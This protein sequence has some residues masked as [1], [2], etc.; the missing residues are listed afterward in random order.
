MT[1]L[2]F[3]L[4]AMLAGDLRRSDPCRPKGDERSSRWKIQGTSFCGYRL[5]IGG[6][7]WIRGHVDSQWCAMELP[8]ERDEFGT[9]GGDCHCWGDFLQPHG[10]CRT[11]RTGR[12]G[13]HRHRRCTHSQC[14]YR[15]NTISTGTGKFTVGVYLGH[16]SGSDGRLHDNRL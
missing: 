7:C 15:Y 14:R 13:I 1:W 11:R 3:T 4:I 5:F 2:V 12:C 10:I 6:N 9:I 16:R 8:D